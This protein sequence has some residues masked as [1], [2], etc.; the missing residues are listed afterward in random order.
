[1]GKR[2]PPS[3]LC[4]RQLPRT[5]EIQFLTRLA[6]RPQQPTSCTPSFSQFRVFVTLVPVMLSTAPV[7][8][9]HSDMD[10][11]AIPIVLE[12]CPVTTECT[13]RHPAGAVSATKRS[14]AQVATC[15]VVPIVLCI[16]SFLEG[17]ANLDSGWTCKC[18]ACKREPDVTGAPVQIILRPG[19]VRR[20]LRTSANVS[21]NTW[22][23]TAAR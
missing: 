21:C 13:T 14:V 16:S 10:P 6:M 15:E 5:R 1:M 17:G 11:A 4:T 12:V 23:R 7:C 19:R 2:H 18:T 3:T 20:K 8:V 22:N 9:M